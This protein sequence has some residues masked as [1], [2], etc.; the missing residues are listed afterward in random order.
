V[1]AVAFLGRDA[2]LAVVD[3]DEVPM[4]ARVAEVAEPRAVLVVALGVAVVA[5]AG[6]LATFWRPERKAPEPSE[7]AGCAVG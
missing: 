5:T 4:S 3:V 7:A 6:L 2:G 1:I